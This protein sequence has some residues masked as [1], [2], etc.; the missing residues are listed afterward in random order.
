MPSESGTAEPVPR[1]AAHGP[2]VALG[3]A[4][5]VPLLSLGPFAFGAWDRAEPTV[6]WLHFAAA[7]TALALLHAGWRGVPATG[8]LTHPFVL[9]PAA[10]ALWSV[11]IA[12]LSQ[13]PLAAMLGPPQSGEG[14]LWYLDL[15]ILTAGGILVWR[16]PAARAAIVLVGGLVALATAVCVL[17]APLAP[18]LRLLP[19]PGF[20]AYNALA[21]LFLGVALLPEARCAAWT[22]W[23]G[24]VALLVAAASVAG[25]LVF[26]AAAAGLALYRRRSAG[27]A[28]RPLRIGRTT[29]AAVVLAATLTPMLAIWLWPA[30]AEIRSLR[31]RELIWDIMLDPGLWDLRTLAIGRGWGHTQDSFVVH[32]NAAGAP[33]WQTDWDFLWRDIF[34]SHN[35]LIEAAHAAGLPG[36]L[37]A[38]GLLLVLPLASPAERRVPATLLA[39]AGGALSAVWFQLPPSLPFM[40][41]AAAS[42]A[43]PTRATTEWRRRGASAIL[44]VTTATGIAAAGILLQQGLDLSAARGAL[45]G[46]PPP[47]AP[48]DFPRDIRGQELALALTTHGVIDALKALDD[49]RHPEGRARALSLFATLR[50]RVDGGE[51]LVLTLAGQSFLA[52]VYFTRELGWLVADIAEGEATWR[53]WLDNALHRAPKR[54]DIAIPYL[55]MLLRDGRAAELAAFVRTLLRHDSHDPVALFYAGTLMMT[56]GDAASRTTGLRLLRTAI[57]NRV[58]RFLP[59]APWLREIAGRHQP[60]PDPLRTFGRAWPASPGAREDSR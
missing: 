37:L 38:L 15:A 13:F 3:L 14:A 5:A 58:D 47:G 21:L 7:L 46:A 10:L 39:A 57:D 42:V 56:R 52:E 34:H 16:E 51:S 49:R 19:V 26:L 2:G 41:L 54:S 18:A 35:Q 53:R 8:A 45:R 20:Y 33:L 40:A 59:V 12:P 43:G 32:L 36:A 6:V 44:A 25:W 31:S 17:L 24:A 23:T 9:P 30:L 27:G 22:A 1:A 29:G 28:A 48:I 4:L 60:E 55:A 11:A 50:N